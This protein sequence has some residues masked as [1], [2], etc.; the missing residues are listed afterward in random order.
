MQWPVTSLCAACLALTACG[1]GSSASPAAAPT[2]A[3]ITGTVSGFG[4]AGQLSLLL[5]NNGVDPIR[6]TGDGNFSFTKKI[7]EGA[8]YDVKVLGTPSGDNCMV[9]H[10]AGTVTH[11]IDSISDIR[12]QC[13]GGGAIAFYNFYVGVTVS[14]LLP[15]QSVT[16]VN[17][18]VN[19][20][21]ANDNGLFVFPGPPYAWQEI[22]GGVAAGY[23]VTVQRNPSGQTCSLNN[24][25]GAWDPSTD[26]FINVIATCK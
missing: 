17:A 16:F 25:S 22:I 2:S 11:G 21:T 26:N 6:V 5:T 13:Q 9:A 24:A 20:L 7:A 18:G 15:G 3:A 23:A 4:T 14:G 19:P 8:A 10:G 1:G 12:V